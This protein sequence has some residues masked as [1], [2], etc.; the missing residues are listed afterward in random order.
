MGKPFY[1]ELREVWNTFEWSRS[2]YLGGSRPPI[3]SPLMCVGSGGSLS[4]AAL[5]ANLH[6]S[7]GGISCVLT[8]LE[9]LDF[10]SRNRDHSVLLLSAGGSNKDI[11]AACRFALE[12]E[13]RH[14][15]VI[16]ASLASELAGMAA[17]FP[18]SSVSEIELPTGK[19]GFLATNSL[20]AMMVVLSRLF[21][22]TNE[23][24]RVPPPEFDQP[25]PTPLLDREHFTVVA[26]GAATIPATDL[27]SKLVEAGLRSV[28]LA[29]FRNFAHGRHHWLAKK[30]TSSSVIALQTPE[31]EQLSRRTLSLLPSDVPQLSL[32]T[33]L[34]GAPAAIDLLFKVFALV[35]A[36]GENT[37]IDPGRPGVPEFGRRLY[38][39]GPVGESKRL[40]PSSSDDHIIGRKLST[41]TH[42]A[43]LTAGE[44]LYR[45][46]LDSIRSQLRSA[47][48][49]A[50]VMDFDGTVCDNVFRLQGL[51]PEVIEVLEELV[52][53]GL[54]AGIATG[55]GPSVP[56]DL[57]AKIAPDLHARIIVGC[58]NGAKIGPLSEPEEAWNG[59]TDEVADE[60]QE[61]EKYLRQQ[62]A[63]AS[64]RIDSRETQVSIYCDSS[65]SPYHSRRAVSSALRQYKYRNY[66]AV[67]ST[68]SC[69]IISLD[70][71]KMAVA[72]ACIKAYNL[73]QS[74][75][76]IGDRGD[77]DGN[78]FDLLNH[79][80]GLSVDQ[81]SSLPEACWNLLPPGVV[82]QAGTIWYLKRLAKHR[83]GWRL[84][85]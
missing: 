75:L 70:T 80:Y 8:P 36:V 16:V 12:A 60:I 51:Q 83:D 84:N 66:R 28:Q 32:R 30:R 14:L 33:T 27:E 3:D 69:D 48:F 61:L 11:K 20:V 79:C 15:G 64:A 39:L 22:D 31:F 25:F 73:D 76:C 45:Q 71:T 77:W 41:G 17:R 18:R 46:A 56:R 43:P 53:K 23:L 47:R 50:V 85:I 35:K 81:V 29:D 37:G 67:W 52:K 4:A 58:Y 74:V 57:Q 63:L 40:K 7:Q 34:Q 82:G 68:H 2:I 6:R 13:P 72:E 62:P 1:N 65:I 44:P 10:A 78:D 54:C 21:G 9:Y 55:R 5:A 38:Q 26:A 49:G 59:R 24:N 42:L 19:D